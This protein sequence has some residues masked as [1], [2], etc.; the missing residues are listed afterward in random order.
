M[1]AVCSKLRPHRVNG[2]YRRVDRLFSS[3][4]FNVFMALVVRLRALRARRFSCSVALA[5]LTGGGGAQSDVRTLG[6][7][8]V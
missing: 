1:C 6:A 8:R 4:K 3:T 5:V 7:R 2:L